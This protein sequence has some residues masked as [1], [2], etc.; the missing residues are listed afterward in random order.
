MSLDLSVDP[1][2]YKWERWLRSVIR[3]QYGVSKRCDELVTLT[4]GDNSSLQ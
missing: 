3:L 4:T 2:P 1:C